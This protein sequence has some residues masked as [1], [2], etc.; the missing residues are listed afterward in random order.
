MPDLLIEIGCEELPA[1]A[2]REAIAQ[3]PV[4]M[5][6]ALSAARLPE[7]EVTVDHSGL[8]GSRIQL[9]ERRKLTPSSTTP[10]AQSR[11]SSRLSEAPRSASATTAPAMADAALPPRPP[12]SGSPFST[13]SSMPCRAPDRR[14]TSAAA[15]DAVFR[16]GSV[17]IRGSDTE[18][19]RTPG[20]A[21]RTAAT[22]SPMPAIAMPRQSKPGPTFEVEPGAYAVARSIEPATIP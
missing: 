10:A 3:V 2:C 1:S 22:R 4:L 16:A 19:T 7:C 11:R 9:C 17:G 14:R 15:R 20:S 21:R 18:R 8:F 13:D 12:A 6:Q 5:A